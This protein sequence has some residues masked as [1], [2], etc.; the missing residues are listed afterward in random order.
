MK[1]TK[2][3]EV[4]HAIDDLARTHEELQKAREL[5]ATLEFKAANQ[6]ARILQYVSKMEQNGE[7]SGS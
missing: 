7:P 2:T 6:R 4:E 3:K 1:L 5:V